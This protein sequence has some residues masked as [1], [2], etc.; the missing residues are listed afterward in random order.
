[1]DTLRSL[2]GE[3]QALLII[4]AHACFWATIFSLLYALRSR[5]WSTIQGRAILVYSVS[6]AVAV[7]LSLYNTLAILY[8]HGMGYKAGITVSLIVYGL[9][10]LASLAL[11]IVLLY[12]QKKDRDMAVFST[13]DEELPFEE[14]DEEDEVK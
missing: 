5:W 11:T 2:P 13:K 9:I 4:V 3:Q 12:M 6:L 1:M 7:D 8:G 14:T 10:G